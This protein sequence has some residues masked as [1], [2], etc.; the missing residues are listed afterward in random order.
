MI[1]LLAL[2]I[3]LLL[4]ASSSAMETK[5]VCDALDDGRIYKGSKKS[6]KYLIEGRDGWFFRSTKDFKSDFSLTPKTL[7]RFSTFNEILKD[8]GVTL[9]IIMPPTRGILHHNFV[10]QTQKHAPDFNADT[11]F[12]SYKSALLQLRLEGISIASFDTVP[13]MKDSFYYPRDHHWTAAG[14]EVSAQKTAGLL[15]PFRDDF[16][17]ENYMTEKTN[18]EVELGGSMEAFVEKQCGVEIQGSKAPIIKTYKEEDLFGDSLPASIALIG[19]SNCTEPEPSYANFAGYLR[20]YLS[21]DVDN[22]SIGGAGIYT[23][24][25]SF[26]ASDAY[27]ERKYKHVI[28]ELASHYNFNGHNFSENFQQMIAAARG[29]C[30]ET[31]LAMKEIDLVGKKVDLALPPVTAASYIYL[32]F[33]KPFKQDFALSY[34][35][36]KGESKRFRFKRD[37]RYPYD[38]TYFVDWGEE[39]GRISDIKL[40][41]PQSY[42]AKKVHVQICPIQE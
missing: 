33:D 39:V 21:A 25:L 10:L 37:A 38:G 42:E 15:K 13:N 40:F 20:Q 7:K 16:V 4:P 19:T 27:R 36:T 28:W 1:R 12:R 23:P 11:A 2:V 17:E 24:M 26:L 8:N 22:L 30:D 9:H 29:S 35:N 5:Y 18:E 31:S 14:A 3:F 34:K 6:Y 41:M 32:Q